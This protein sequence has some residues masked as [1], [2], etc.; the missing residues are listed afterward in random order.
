MTNK[1]ININNL[2]K[3]YSLKNSNLLILENIDFS[4]FEGDIIS[5]VGPSGCGKSTFLN[6]IG[7]LDS[8]FNGIYEFLNNNSGILLFL[9]NIFFN[10]FIFLYFL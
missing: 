10:L 8:E 9:F 4:L 2:N 7:L 1:I 6:I 5:I 3:I